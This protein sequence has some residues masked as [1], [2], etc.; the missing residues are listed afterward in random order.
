MDLSKALD[1]SDHALLIE[2]LKELNLNETLL[3]WII[4]YIVSKK[5]T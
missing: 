3:D 1:A 5:Y 4:S 2:K